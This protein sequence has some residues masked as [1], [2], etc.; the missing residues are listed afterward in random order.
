[1]ATNNTEMLA[2]LA[3][4]QQTLK[5]LINR[6]VEYRI[7]SVKYTK[8]NRAALL[9]SIKSTYPDCSL[10]QAYDGSESPLGD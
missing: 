1:M 10:C 3:A 5:E 4:K 9:T 7:H 6:V 8:A 2:H